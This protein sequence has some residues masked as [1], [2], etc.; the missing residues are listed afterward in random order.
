MGTPTLTMED[1]RKLRA[2]FCIFDRT[3]HLHPF[4]WKFPMVVWK[5]AWSQTS[6]SLAEKCGPWIEVSLFQIRLVIRLDFIKVRKAKPPT[7]S[8]DSD[9]DKEQEQ[10]QQDYQD[11][12]QEDNR[13]K[14]EVL[15]WL[16]KSIG[17][18]IC[19]QSILEIWCHFWEPG[20]PEELT[21]LAAGEEL[22]VLVCTDGGPAS[23]PAESYSCV[24]KHKQVMARCHAHKTM[25]LQVGSYFEI[26]CSSLIT[27]PQIFPP[28]SDCPTPI[29][30]LHHHVYWKPSDK[31][32]DQAA[33]VLPHAT[34]LTHVAECPPKTDNSDQ[35]HQSE[36]CELSPDIIQEEMAAIKRV[37]RG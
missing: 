10:E 4:L 24:Q 18:K 13:G 11:D 34:F 6:K 20:D 3:S 27:R 37:R 16:E 14:Q 19:D 9:S 7:G 29:E 22:N 17:N 36:K 21:E 12:N 30:I 32:R 8:G 1:N 15:T 23:Q 25:F 2:D 5:V 33:Y 28:P 35:S 26:G 31:S